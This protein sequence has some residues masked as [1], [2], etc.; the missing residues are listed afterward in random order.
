MTSP[1]PAQIQLGEFVFDTEQRQLTRAGAVTLLEPKV[2]D[3]LC[4]FIEHPKRF[5]P[6]EEL[7]QQVWAG[8]VVTDTAVR[9]TISKLRV[10]LGDTDNEN[11]RYIKTQ[12]KLG[13]QLVCSIGGSSVE[14]VAA[15]PAKP[16]SYRLI[17]ASVAALV[18]LTA[19]ALTSWY[20][21]ADKATPALFA[22]KPDVLLDVDGVMLNLSQSRDQRY[23]AFIGRLDN[24]QSWQLYL[25]DTEQGLL[26]KI[27]ATVGQ[28]RFVSFMAA[29]TELAVT[30][31]NE[32]Q[33]ASL[34]RVKLDGSDHFAS[35]SG[36]SELEM[37]G[38]ATAIDNETILIG[39]VL[40]GSDSFYQY[41]FNLIDNQIEPFSYS[42]QRVEDALANISPD[43]S[44]IALL[45]RYMADNKVYLQVYNSDKALLQEMLIATEDAFY[46]FD[47]L[48]NEQI[49]LRTNQQ[50]ELIDLTTQQ[51]RTVPEQ[52]GF[53]AEFILSDNGNYTAIQ[54]KAKH[55]Q[56]YLGPW[57]YQ[58]QYD[59]HFQL[60]SVVSAVEFSQQDGVMW[61]TDQQDSGNWV[62]Q[63]YQ[64]ATGERS[65]VF[66]S[67]Q[68]FDFVAGHNASPWLLLRQK[69]QLLLI[70]PQTAAQR[71]ITTS[72]QGVTQGIFSADGQSV[73]YPVQISGQWFVYQY[74]LDADK[75]QP[76]LAGYKAVLP[77]NDGYI[78]VAADNT[79]EQLTAD[80]SRLRELYTAEQL[81]GLSSRVFLNGNLVS[82]ITQTTLSDYLLYTFN[83]DT[84]Q[85]YQWQLPF[86]DFGDEVSINPQGD[87]VLF[88]SGVSMTYQLVRGSYTDN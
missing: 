53:K 64:P 29:D 61:L 2:F 13:Y 37:L 46:R 43:G 81:V 12:M 75:H 7:H 26:R 60:A 76:F 74:Q 59:S 83:L 35:I 21:V 11:P 15:K 40:P 50:L 67:A 31:F 71:I 41:R 78:A 14:E 38:G 82:L 45:R 79:V 56:F 27:A 8:R 36:L 62:L 25:F 23:L 73:L 44:K 65:T 34:Y 51:R 32:Q 68:R 5:I 17:I 22:A 1:L 28:P 42:Q 9:R 52:D 86:A 49:L 84:A 10:A 54:R 58:G 39:A 85:R 57:P 72:T 6:L 16:L 47:W 3:L 30:V 88:S 48:G 55:K 77:L 18:L 69:Q 66:S 20:F 63:R 19:A 87:R 80:F 70:N 24:Q 33:K 4:Y